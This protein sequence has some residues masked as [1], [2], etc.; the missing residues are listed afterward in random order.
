MFVILVQDNGLQRLLP[1]EVIREARP[2]DGSGEHP[3]ARSYAFIT[4]PLGNLEQ[5]YLTAD[6][7]TL[8]NA[9]NGTR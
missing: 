2:W 5:V 8:L 4:D 3:N 9:L 6:L 7:V 1:D